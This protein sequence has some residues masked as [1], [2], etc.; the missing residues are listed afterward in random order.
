MRNKNYIAQLLNITADPDAVY[1]LQ[2]TGESGGNRVYGIPTQ[3]V[4]FKHK[5]VSGQL[6][7]KVREEWVT[8]GIA[9]IGDVTLVTGSELTLSNQIEH[10]DI[11]YDIVSQLD[12]RTYP[13]TYYLYILRKVQA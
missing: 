3:K 7:K 13:G 12:A 1:E 10:K 9:E 5:L 6:I 8:T 11:K 2:V 4:I